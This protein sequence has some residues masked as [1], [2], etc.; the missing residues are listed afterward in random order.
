MDREK[1]SSSR[2]DARQMDQVGA[3]SVKAERDVSAARRGFLAAPGPPA[4]LD[5]HRGGGFGA[6]RRGLAHM[7]PT[8]ATAA[9]GG[10]SRSNSKPRGGGS[11]RRST[12]GGELGPADAGT[13][14]KRRASA[15]VA[16]GIPGGAGPS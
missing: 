9:R 7:A 4:G 6:R 15:C 14:G 2:D 10:E 1:T 5:R 11:L 12:P 13:H 3:R 8:A 16:R